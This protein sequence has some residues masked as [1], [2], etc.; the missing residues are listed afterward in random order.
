MLNPFPK[1]GAKTYRDFPL[2]ACAPNAGVKIRSIRGLLK[3]RKKKSSPHDAD[4]R[5][6]NLAGY[7]FVRKHVEKETRGWF[8]Q[9]IEWGE[10]RDGL[11]SG[12]LGTFSWPPQLHRY[13]LEI[14][15]GGGKKKRE[16][17]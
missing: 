2:G 8:F 17:E 10:P 7:P 11:R 1:G 4:V 15:R 3:G 6:G 5:G 16:K 14:P 12:T 13:L 9:I